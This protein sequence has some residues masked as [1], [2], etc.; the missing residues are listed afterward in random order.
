MVNLLF[1]V[2]R[3]T[4]STGSCFPRSLPSSVLLICSRYRHTDINE[5]MPRS[6]VAAI[7]EQIKKI[8]RYFLPH[9]DFI[10]RHDR[11]VSASTER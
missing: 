4:S 7:F 1:F 8:G 9:I 5:R 2:R 6:E 3:G 11:D 10:S